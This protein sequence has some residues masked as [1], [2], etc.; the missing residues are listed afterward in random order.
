MR[1]KTDENLP[2]EVTELLRQYQH[3]ALSVQEQQMAGQGDPQIARVCQSEQRALVTCDLDF[4][5][6]RAYPPED[7][8]GII[9]LRPALQTVSSLL[10]L[11]NRALPLMD[12]QPL[13]GCIWIVDDHRVR[14]RGAGPQDAP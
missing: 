12:V 11:M 4:A 10:R 5:D 1:F 8:H 13:D 14:I 3:D 7:Y 6:I 9:V 2:V